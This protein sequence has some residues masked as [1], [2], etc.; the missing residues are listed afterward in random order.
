MPWVCA[1]CGEVNYEDSSLRCV[2]GQDVSYE[3]AIRFEDEPARSITRERQNLALEF[4]G[5]AREYFRIWIVNLCLTLLTVGIFSAWAKVRKKRYFYSNIVL[6]GTPFQYLG[7]PLPILKGRILAVA[8]FAV[9]Y[10]T[11][12]FFTSVLPYVLAAGTAL[13]PWVIV[14]SAAFNARYSAYRNITF[15]FHGKYVDALKAFYPWALIPVFITGAILGWWNSE[16]MKILI[17]VLIGLSFPWL[18]RQL[19]NFIVSHTYYGD[20]KG[21]FSAGGRQ[22]AWV[23]FVSG[24]IVA[25][26]AII[27]TVVVM[28]AFG[29]LRN[30][31]Y[32]LLVYGLLAYSGYV[33]AFAYSQANIGNLVWNNTL[34][35]PLRFRSTL[36]SLEMAKL[37]L[38]NA[39]AI[40]ASGGMLIPWAVIRTLKYRA[41]NMNVVLEGSLEEFH[42]VE[43][44]SVRAT[45]AELGE[46][47]DVDL[48]L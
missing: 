23:Y 5:S 33:L 34:L 2:C 38:T 12:H 11:S 43:A 24:W 16:K 21:Q 17:S 19:K 44:V 1:E 25:G 30:S 20:R 4:R 41:D 35:G 31:R 7:Q 10:A 37:Y 39:V 36:R 13:A 3:D 6:E 40:I 8:L 27:A 46:L 15:S 9:Y 47:F 18:V 32:S 48:S 26:L 45:G 29:T 14:S 22:F 42:G 28:F